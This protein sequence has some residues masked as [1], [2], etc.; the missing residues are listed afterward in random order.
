[1][2]TPQ[3]P[4]LHCWSGDVAS[5]DAV[6]VPCAA[7]SGMVGYFYAPSE[8][9]SFFRLD[10]GGKPVDQKGAKVDIDS[11]YEFRLFNSTLDIRMRRDGGAWRVAELSE[12]TTSSLPSG[13]KLEAGKPNDGTAHRDHQYLLWGQLAGKGP[14]NPGWTR[15][16]TA[17]IGELWVPFA[18]NGKSDGIA[19]KAR[20]YFTVAAD[21]N[22]VFAAERLTGFDGVVRSGA[23]NTG[24]E[25]SNG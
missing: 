5:A 20:E 19:L 12:N 14:T 8:K 7:I 13:L 2:T 15:L 9:P 25:A 3:A 22:V 4:V 24:A 16:T 11:A 6:L 18:L 1:M 17:R 23:A 21:G 10:G